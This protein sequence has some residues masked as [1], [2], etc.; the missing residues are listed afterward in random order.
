M[1]I[2]NKCRGKP[3]NKTPCRE[4]PG[5]FWISDFRFATRLPAR[6]FSD[7]EG[8]K[9][10]G[11]SGIAKRKLPALNFLQVKRRRIC[12]LHCRGDDGGFILYDLRLTISDY[13]GIEK[14]GESWIEEGQSLTVNRRLLKGT[15]PRW[16]LKPS[17]H[18]RA[19]RNR[20]SEIGNKHARDWVQNTCAGEFLWK[21]AGN[22]DITIIVRQAAR[23][24][25]TGEC[26][27]GSA[28]LLFG[29]C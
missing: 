16:G 17:N 19:I 14:N 10:P 26:A 22:N 23:T 4:G 25:W 13:V 11:R 21:P 5:G 20:R 9:K 29:L 2:K 3:P 6:H 27:S 12:E 24:R 18:D 15:K 28:V 8:N 1:R 7:L